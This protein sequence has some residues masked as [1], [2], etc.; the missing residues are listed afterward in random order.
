MRKLM[1]AVA[2]VAAVASTAVF[3]L[4]IKLTDEERTACERE[5][6]C[7]FVSRGWLMELISQ[8]RSASCEKSI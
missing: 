8:V 4:E 1:I 2:V 7:M 5:G 6:G 3:A